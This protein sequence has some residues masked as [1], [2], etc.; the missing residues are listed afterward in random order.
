LYRIAKTVIAAHQHALIGQG[1]SIP[2]ALQMTWPCMRRHTCRKPCSEVRVADL[3]CPGKIAALHCL[4]PGIFGTGRLGPLTRHRVHAHAIRNG[5]RSSDL[6]NSPDANEPPDGTVYEQS[7]QLGGV[8][9][10]IKQ[11]CA[12]R[13]RSKPCSAWPM[14]TR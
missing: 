5:R 6:H 10:G 9:A 12:T 2:D 1:S 3:P 14:P 8:G 7:V 13:N 4:D 11:P